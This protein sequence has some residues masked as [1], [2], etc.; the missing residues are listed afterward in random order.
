MTKTSEQLLNEIRNLINEHLAAGDEVTLPNPLTTIKQP[1]RVGLIVGHNSINTGAE[2]I[3]IPAEFNFWSEV[4]TKL[5]ARQVSNKQEGFEIFFVPTDGSYRSKHQEL[6]NSIKSP[7]QLDYVFELHYN[8]FFNPFAHGHEVL[9]LNKTVKQAHVI[10][11]AL[12]DVYDRRAIRI[13]ARDVKV[14]SHDFNS[15]GFANIELGTRNLKPKLGYFILEPFFG[16]SPKDLSEL[17]KLSR[18]NNIVN[19]ISHIYCDL[20]KEL[21]IANNET[22]MS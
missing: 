22:P 10:R 6:N 5:L 18:T 17:S 15:R 11:Q 21:A 19:S 16:T 8:A 12:I 1:L 13:K 4:A 9:A 20:F 2:G 7:A 3:N 14:L